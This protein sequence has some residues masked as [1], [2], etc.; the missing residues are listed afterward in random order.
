[1]LHHLAY[2]LK[3]DAKGAP[4]NSQNIVIF[5][6]LNTDLFFFLWPEICTLKKVSFFCLPSLKNLW[7]PMPGRHWRALIL[8]NID[9]V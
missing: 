9:K 6:N 5:N 4:W 3:I 2:A 1:M 8:I 7:T